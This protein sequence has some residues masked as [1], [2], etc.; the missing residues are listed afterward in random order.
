[1][2]MVI[3]QLPYIAPDDL[4]EGRN[5]VPAFTDKD[6]LTRQKHKR[7]WKNRKYSDSRLATDRRIK[8]YRND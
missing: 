2:Q 6:F 8:C 1:M 7:N 4:W 3:K 5:P